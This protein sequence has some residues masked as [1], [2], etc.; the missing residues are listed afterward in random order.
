M[1]ELVKK[2][3][4]DHD[5]E[6]E[7]LGAKQALKTMVKLSKIVGKPLAMV[8]GDGNVAGSLS[9]EISP[10]LLGAAVGAMVE[11]L[12]EG[13]TQ[14]LC[15]LLTAEKCLCDGKKINFDMHY[16]GRLDHM[17]KVLAAALEVQYGNFF[18]GL[19]ATVNQAK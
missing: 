4:G 19:F 3:I 15:E 11:R 10:D 5:Y 13:E 1:R 17:F 7:Q 14:A 9:R 6:F 16:E 2:T 8:V 12:D 18:S